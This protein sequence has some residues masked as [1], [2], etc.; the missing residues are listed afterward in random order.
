MGLDKEVNNI[1]YYIEFIELKVLNN[2][3]FLF[4]YFI[5]KGNEINNL[6]LE[7]DISLV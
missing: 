7:Y 1:K 6:I 4:F 5:I 2:E 3:F